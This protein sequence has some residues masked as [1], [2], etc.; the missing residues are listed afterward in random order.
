MS[1]HVLTAALAENKRRRQ[2]VIIFDNGATRHI[3]RNGHYL[4]NIRKSTP[5]S[6]QGLAGKISMDQ[7][8][9]LDG[10]GLAYLSPEAPGNIVSHSQ[11]LKTPGVTLSYD[12]K[13]PLH[14]WTLKVDD[15]VKYVFDLQEN[16]LWECDLDEFDKE[17]GLLAKP[18]FGPSTIA[19]NKAKYTVRDLR[20]AQLAYDAIEQLGHASFETL[21]RILRNGTISD[22]PFNLMDVRRAKDIWGKHEG[23][24]RGK[25][26]HKKGTHVKVNPIDPVP[27]EQVHQTLVGDIMTLDG[28]LYMVTTSLPLGYL[29]ISHV[30]T[31]TIMSVHTALSA[32]IHSL[33]ER[34]C[35]IDELR[36]DG[37]KAVKALRGRLAAT[38]A[39]E[40]RSKLNML[41]KSVHRG[42]S[43]RHREGPAHHQG[44]SAEL[45]GR[46]RL[47]SSPIGKAIPV[48]VRCFAPEPAPRRGICGR[49][50]SFRAAFR[51]KAR[52]EQGCEMQVRSIWTV[53]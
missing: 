18:F 35:E 23:S 38:T 34:G 43:A 28:G 16:G 52:L 12:D 19:R 20:G 27:D 14:R 2:R 48:I 51:Q 37:E 22:I 42:T 47:E 6:F 7:V 33:T 49:Y 39:A 26:T 10:L 31:K 50:E 15:E 29:Q 25:T 11:L 8:G 4:Q 5:R 45:S 3:F 41:F 17:F 36:F 9:T 44:T 1:D 46:F 30:P 21:E 13:H 53:T 32:H 24:V 40:L